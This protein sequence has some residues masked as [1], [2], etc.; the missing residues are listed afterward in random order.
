MEWPEAAR[1]V[2]AGLPEA[3]RVAGWYVLL[4]TGAVAVLT[5]IRKWLGPAAAPP[6]SP[7]LS[8]EQVVRT[9]DSAI[10]RKFNG[11]PSRIE[12]MVEALSLKLDRLDEKVEGQGERL[13]RVEERQAARGD[14]DGRER[15]QR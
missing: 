7:G 13:A 11:S 3:H 12:R 4:A 9:V 1:D 14:W 6:P 2:V 8:L 15:R 5:A 10:D